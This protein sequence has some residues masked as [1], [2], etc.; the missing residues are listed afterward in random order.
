MGDDIGG[1]G[2]LCFQNFSKAGNTIYQKIWYK[3]FKHLELISNEI[4]PYKQNL[5]TIKPNSG[6]IIILKKLKS[7]YRSKSY[8]PFK[9]IYKKDNLIKK[10][11][12]E[13]K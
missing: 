11:M 5:L 7:E 10:A 6:L 9:V 2:F 1:Y 13:G 4:D 12:E 3:E 8:H